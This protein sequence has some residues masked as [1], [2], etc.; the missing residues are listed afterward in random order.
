MKITISWIFVA[1]CLVVIGCG[2]GGGGGG[3]TSTTSTTTTTSTTSTTG[4]TG[5]DQGITGMVRDVTSNPIQNARVKFYSNTGT[6]VGTATTNAAGKFSA[7]LPLSAKRFTV[8]ISGINNSANFFNQFGYGQYEYL[9]NDANCTAKAPVFADGQVKPLP[10]DI[11]ITQLW[12][13]PP[14]PPDGCISG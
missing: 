14:S 12:F 9:G 3:T 10:N 11:V 8:D 4:T 7:E 2:G 5:I 1:L 6:L 13:G